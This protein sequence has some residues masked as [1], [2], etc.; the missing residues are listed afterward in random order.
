MLWVQFI[1]SMEEEGEPETIEL[2]WDIRVEEG[3]Q[4][5]HVIQAVDLSERRAQIKHT[6]KP[7]DTYEENAR[8]SY[9]WAECGLLM[10]VTMHESAVL[11][12][13]DLTSMGGKYIKLYSSR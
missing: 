3:Q 8:I 6:N 2:I 10:E 1:P 4:A 7:R 13:R 12:G 9:L 11:S 5:A